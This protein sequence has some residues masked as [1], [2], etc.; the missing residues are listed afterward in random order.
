VPWDT[1]RDVEA[2]QRLFTS[3]GSE[4]GRWIARCGLVDAEPRGEE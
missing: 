2:Y 4:P 3:I 1:N